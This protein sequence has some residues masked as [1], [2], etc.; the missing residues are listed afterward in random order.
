MDAVTQHQEHQTQLHYLLYWAAHQP[1][2]TYFV[3]PFPHGE[4][5][6][7]TWKDV[8]QQ[9]RC[10]AAYLQS[11]QLPERSHIA[12][13][14]RNSAHWIM[15]DF[16]IWMAGHVSVPLYT[17]LTAEGST[18]VLTHSDSKLLFIG[19]LDGHGDSWHQVKPALPADLKCIRLPMSSDIDA[20]T[21]DDIVRKTA[22]LQEMVLP[23]GSDLATIM[24]TSGSTGLPKG[25][26]HSFTTMLSATHALKSRYGLS[27][28]DRMLSYLPL[29]HAAERIFIETL[30]VVG[31]TT[32][33]FANSLETFIDD[34]NRAKP[35][36]FMSVPRLWTKF[37]QGIND[38]IPP[39]AQS[40]LFNIPVLGNMIKKK[41]LTK[42]GLNHVRYAFTGSAPLPAEII[43]WY[44]RLGL[45]LLEVYGMSENFAYSHIAR[46]GD[47]R[48]GYIGHVQ[49]GVECKI[50]DNGEILVKSPG[51]MLGYYKN[52]EKTA[53]DITSDFY[54]RTG[55]MGEI[56][57]TGRLKITGRIKDIFKTS[58]GKYVK[59]VP[60]EQELGNHEFI[61]AVCVG[62]ANQPQPIAFIMLSEELRKE[63]AQG[64]ARSDIEPSLQ[65]LLQ[66]TN[67]G[68]EAHEQMDY[69]VII[70]EPW[71]MENDLLT[72]TMKIKRNKIEARY[73]PYLDHWSKQNKHVIWE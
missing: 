59:P 3:Q 45:E 61:E 5:I 73:E 70:N 46:P 68:L 52:P 17:T 69:L 58:K 33:F 55:D 35:T 32:V 20:P 23:Q 71:T 36:L 22:P 12:I 54:L 57:E 4:I 29:A 11:L 8:A 25:V 44:R 42:L 64:K 26:M 27:E 14:G 47:Y 16:A 50:D 37:Y 6:K 51:T 38:K 63:I 40:I 7:Y 72:P 15:A 49:P 19:K 9:V 24:Y 62:G 41:L 31:G 18:H 28:K 39:R 56:D 21:W 65:Q 66:S 30:S 10:M 43:N 1:D 2:A 48:S 34:L 60:I 67:A 53:E 13:Y